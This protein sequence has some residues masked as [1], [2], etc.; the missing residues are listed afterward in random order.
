MDKIKTKMNIH[1][2][3]RWNK[4]N[5][6]PLLVDLQ[7]YAKILEI[8]LTIFQKMSIDIQHEP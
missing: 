6:S 2:I 1:K 8:N 5:I 4:F 7:I 3:R